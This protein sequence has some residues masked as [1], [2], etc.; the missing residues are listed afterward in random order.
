MLD[1]LIIGGG[2]SGLLTAWYLQQ[3]GQRVAVLDRQE[4]GQESSWA[5]GGILSPLYPWRYTT[6]ITALATWSQQ[7]FPQF[8]LDLHR[9]S[10]IDPGYR[11]SGLL[12]LNQGNDA[13]IASWQSHSQQALQCWQTPDLLQAEP[14]IQVSSDQS[15]LRL[16]NIGQVRNPHFVA[17]LIAMLALAKHRVILA[18]NQA[19]LQ[20][21]FNAKRTQITGL[22]TAQQTWQA[23]NVVIC[24]G[25]WSQPLLADTD[26][27][28]AIEI[29]PVRGQMI[30]F[31]ADP[32]LL[33]HILLSNQ[34]YLIPR[35]D[36]RILAGSTLEHVGFNKQTTATAL[37]EL[38]TFATDLLPELSHYP[39]EKHWAG[40]RPGT[41]NGVPYIGKHPH[42]N[43]LF[44]NAGHYR[45][46]VVLSLASAHLLADTLLERQPILNPSDYAWHHSRGSLPPS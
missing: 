35:R 24:A 26:R 40:L 34:R 10:G 21:C 12:I 44:I 39:I 33:Q 16:P 6:A 15:H 29:A 37:A 19:V 23:K 8:L 25:A 2:I 14:H 41:A 22:R 27:P 18:P 45:N 13:S 42:M 46:G 3:A 1:T 7:Q 9:H 28:L 4:F 32:K 38:N 5:G 11:Q 20:L 43:G 17:G 31:K 30:I 36:G